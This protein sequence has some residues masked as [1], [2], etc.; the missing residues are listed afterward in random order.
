MAGLIF[1]ILGLLGLVL[2]FL[3]GFLF[4]T[5]ALIFLSISSSQIRTWLVTHTVRFPKLH[6]AFL[7]LERWVVGY[8][9]SMEDEPPA[10]GDS[11]QTSEKI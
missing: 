8:T 4:L 9:G 2:P 5:L 1:L 10:A 6:N 3:Q 11:A 7:K